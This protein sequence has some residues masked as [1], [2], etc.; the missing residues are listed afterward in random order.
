MGKALLT[1]LSTMFANLHLT[2]K[3]AP[4]DVS[5]AL[6]VF[7][8]IG[9]SQPQTF[10]PD[11]TSLIHERSLTTGTHKPLLPGVHRNFSPS[12]SASSTAPRSTTEQRHRQMTFSRA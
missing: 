7:E 1:A 9:P 5:V 6:A 2:E 11:C 12:A 4:S 3:D 10:L 8:S